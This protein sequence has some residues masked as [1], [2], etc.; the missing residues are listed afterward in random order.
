MDEYPQVVLWLDPGGTTGLAWIEYTPQGYTFDCAQAVGTEAAAE[1]IHR[2]ISCNRSPSGGLWW[3]KTTEERHQV[4]VG[5]EQYI[6]TAG[7]G[8]SGNPTPSLEV[9]GATK[10][11]CHDAGS[12]VLP[13]VPASYRIAATPELLKAI[14]W[15]RPGQP[16]AMDAARHLAAWLMRE[17]QARRMYR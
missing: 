2:L 5:W 15:W 7:G 8:R 13:P 6:V 12:R 4:W 17:K 10:W 16:H 14:G 3:P 9:I 1:V 11:I